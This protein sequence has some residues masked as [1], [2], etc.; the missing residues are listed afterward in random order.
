MGELEGLQIVTIRDRKVVDFFRVQ[1]HNLGHPA[2][3]RLA[4]EARAVNGIG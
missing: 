3:D 1:A 2:E 4:P